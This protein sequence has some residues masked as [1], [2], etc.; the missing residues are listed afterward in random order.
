[1]VDITRTPR[2]PEVNGMSHAKISLRAEQRALRE[3]MRERGLAHELI[4]LEFARR[5]RL[6]PRAA[7]RIAYGWSLTEAAERINSY[8]AVRGLGS[9]S[10]VAMTAA[11][12][13][14]HEN[15]PGAA[16]E[17]TGRK[18]TPYLLS[19][20]AGVYGCA[21][22]DLLDSADYKHMP[23]SDRLVLDAVTRN[24][25]RPLDSTTARKVLGSGD[26]MPTTP[27]SPSSPI[28]GTADMRGD[29]PCP[30]WGSS[31]AEVANMT[32]ELLKADLGRR[33]VMSVW[34]VAALAE[35]LGRWLLDAEDR[36]V[37]GA[38][39]RR[40]GRVDVDAV[41]AMC[42]AFADADH[43]LGGGHARR[44][45]VCY[46]DDVVA[47]LLA[48]KYS[49]KTGKELF[50]AV[51]RLFDIAGFMCFDSDQQGLGQKYFIA[52]LRM[53]KVSGD[54]ALGA[55]ILT[56]MSIQAQHQ[57]QGQVAVVLAD[58]A[59]ATAT[60]SGS[61]STLARCH[62]VR[63]RALALQG[64]PAASDRALSQAERMLERVGP[65]E[66]PPWITFFTPQQL[67]AESMYAAAELRRA[68]QVQHRAADVLSVTSE[69]MQRRQVLA[70]ATLAASYLPA[71][72]SPADT[73]DVERAC[74]VLRGVLP[75]IASQTS[76]RALNL[77]AAVRS[78][79]ADYP[80]LTAVQQ[81]ERDLKEC[82]T[83][84][85]S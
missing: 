5:Y 68:D 23:A 7:W 1:M 29:S 70:T 66:E 85:G 8:A 57:R 69:D 54:E 32:A 34:A 41:W 79:L 40:V 28:D 42:S 64:D 36:G 12:L 31:P 50:T 11:H 13:C 9:G 44:T 37:A 14:E 39:S 25:A 18:P 43:R 33:D 35:P 20:L 4:A 38:G 74:D 46:A 47:P 72:D 3:E 19:L 56:D 52:A 67:A 55:H 49:E 61:A 63:A 45:L 81:L 51:A 84:V 65:H 6:R 82:L 2:E 62:A 73:A 60:R 80:E 83:S 21:V 24:Q 10:T 30:A 76:M 15:W 75:V 71:D 27:D 53:A 78:R 58:A 77:V 26:S 17:P 22:D 16:H 59:I 48:G